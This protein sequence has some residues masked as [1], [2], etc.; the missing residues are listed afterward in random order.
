MATLYLDSFPYLDALI[1]GWFHQDFD[2]AGDT[3]EEVVAAYKKS[4]PPEDWLGTEADIKRFLRTRDEDQ[5]EGDF[6][7]LFTPGVEPA[8]WD[9]TTREWLMKIHDLL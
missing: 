4:N 7:R 6:V 5:I 9:M 2:L 8:G 3:L 1:G